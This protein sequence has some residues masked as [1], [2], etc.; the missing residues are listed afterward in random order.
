MRN[1][2]RETT[3]ETEA[4][5]RMLHEEEEPEMVRRSLPTLRISF[6]QKNRENRNTFEHRRRLGR[7][8]ETKRDKERIL[9]IRQ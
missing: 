5:F 4:A 8:R 1:V 6:P 9:L 2:N 7:I 3:E